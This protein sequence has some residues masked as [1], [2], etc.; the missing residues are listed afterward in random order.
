[1]E[2]LFWRRKC[3][4]TDLWHGR[5]SK[6]GKNPK[7]RVNIYLEPKSGPHFKMDGCGDFHPI[8]SCKISH[9]LVRHPTDSQPFIEVGVLGMRSVYNV[10]QNYFASSWKLAG[11][12]YFFKKTQRLENK[13]LLLISPILYTPENWWL[14]PE[15]MPLEKVNHQFWR[16]KILCCRLYL[17]FSI[18][19]VPPKNVHVSTFHPHTPRWWQH[20]VC[21]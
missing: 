2:L 7:V 8:F 20:L 15:S 17:F 16:F 5:A 13:R 21:W 4:W 14:E 9:D 10:E 19:L 11:H 1:M 18:F 3:S 6:H 12:N